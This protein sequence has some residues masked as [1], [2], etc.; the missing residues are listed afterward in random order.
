THGKNFYGHMLE[1][2][3]GLNS[4]GYGE[5][6]I[7]VAAMNKNDF[8]EIIKQF[9]IKCTVIEYLGENY[10]K[11]LATCQYLFND[12]TFRPFFNKRN[13]QKYFN[14]WHGTPLKYLGKD[15]NNLTQIGNVQRNLFSSDA[16]IVNNTYTAE[17]LIHA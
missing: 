8:Q 12:T 11:K 5:D 16:I 10:S 17:K 9:G 4:L 6:N 1:V 7:F 2:T 3:K 14:I 15:M 13:E